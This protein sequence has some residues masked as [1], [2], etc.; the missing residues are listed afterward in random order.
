[1][2]TIM[3]SMEDVEKLKINP[4]KFENR[5]KLVEKRLS[6]PIY[7]AVAP[8]IESH[9]MMAGTS[10]SSGIELAAF[11]ANS[12]KFIITVLMEQGKLHKTLPGMSK[13]EKEVD[14]V[15]GNVGQYL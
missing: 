8:L 13:K 5:S 2:P 3:L 1:M 6:R 14:E 11:L 10:F 9:V 15:G 7:E 4:E 12:S